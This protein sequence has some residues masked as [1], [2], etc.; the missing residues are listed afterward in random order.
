MA[1]GIKISDLNFTQSISGGSLIPIVQD[2][3][4][5]TTSVS[6]IAAV[7][8]DLQQVL[9]QGNTTT[10]SISSSNNIIANDGRF[11]NILSA[12]QNLTD[13]FNTDTSIDLQDVTDNGNT[14][15]NSL[16]VAALSASGNIYAEGALTQ[17]IT[18]GNMELTIRGG[19]IYNATDIT[20]IL[21]I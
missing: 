16:S 20:D 10:L 21:G 14:T 7:T 9:T 2:G 11:V 3:Q 4:T 19:L 8:S 18:A 15:T 6:S 1:T 5:L 12:G 13:I 17:T